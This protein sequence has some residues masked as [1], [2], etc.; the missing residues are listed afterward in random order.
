[1]GEKKKNSYGGAA[2]GSHYMLRN[3]EHKKSIGLEWE[4]NF[5]WPGFTISTKIS[6]YGG[7]ADGSHYMLGNL[8]QEKSIGLEWE[9]NFRWPGFT[10][11]TKI[12]GAMEGY[13]YN[14]YFPTAYGSPLGREMVAYV[15][16]VYKVQ[17]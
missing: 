7:A 9:E 2:D 14:P 11:R 15:N 17:F 1:M 3:L 16:R 5:R 6:S 4:E 13:A 8:E 10:I 12:S